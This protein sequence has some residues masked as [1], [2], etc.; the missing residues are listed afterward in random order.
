MPP[1]A[2]G[3]WLSGFLRGA[4]LK[5]LLRRTTRYGYEETVCIFTVSEVRSEMLRRRR[6]GLFSPYLKNIYW[7]YS[8]R[9]GTNVNVYARAGLL[10]WF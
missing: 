3:R 2:G 8:S 5:A 9:D 7:K 4:A 1:V 10:R 6:F